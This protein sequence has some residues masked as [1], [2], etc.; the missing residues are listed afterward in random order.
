MD[1]AY[2][3]QDIQH[4]LDPDFEEDDDMI[5]YADVPKIFKNMKKLPNLTNEKLQL[6]VDA[7]AVIALTGV[8]SQQVLD[9]EN[10]CLQSWFYECVAECTPTQ[11]D[12]VIGLLE[13]RSID[14]KLLSTFIQQFKNKALAKYIK[15]EYAYPFFKSLDEQIVHAETLIL[16]N[17]NLHVH[18]MH[19]NKL[20]TETNKMITFTNNLKKRRSSVLDN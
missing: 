19:K 1:E 8:L 6:H 17:Q 12:R 20:N 9:V 4:P 3:V 15:D 2:G 11:F 18:P 7:C 10:I 14:F 5:L 13:M 16:A